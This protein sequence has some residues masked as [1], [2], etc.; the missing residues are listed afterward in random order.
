MPNHV[1][2]TITAYGKETDLANIKKGLK[3]KDKD[4]HLCFNNI[5]PMPEN[6]FTGDVGKKEKEKYGKDNWYDWSISNW[7]TKWNAYSQPEEEPKING[8]AN[9]L[10]FIKDEKT[11]AV[12]TYHFCTAWSP[13]PRILEKLSLKYPNCIFKYA[14]LEEGEGFSGIDF[15]HDGCIVK[16]KVLRPKYQVFNPIESLKLIKEFKALKI[17]IP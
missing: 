9:S 2:S 14:Y 6:I 16:E 8:E 11:F 12:I 15:W 10:K 13:V 4:Q 7:G 17:K 1:Y 3:G 5:I